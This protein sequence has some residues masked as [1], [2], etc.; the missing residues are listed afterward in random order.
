[1][2]RP[3]VNGTRAAARVLTLAAVLWASGQ[4]PCLA[5]QA[6][7]G[8]KA[9]GMTAAGTGSAGG[10]GGAEAPAPAGEG[11]VRGIVEPRA[12]AQLS[13]EITARIVRMP[14][15]DGEAFSKGDVLAEYDCGRLKAAWRAARAAHRAAAL[16]A[17]SKRRLV[18]FQAAGK[19]EASIA[20]AES[21]RAA[22]EAEA[23]ALEVRKCRVLAPFSGRV[24]ERH[25]QTHE[26]PGAGRPL[27]TIVDTGRLEVEMIAPSRWLAWVR[28]G[29]GF[30]FRLDETGNVL[31]GRL[32][33]I[34]A[35]VDAVSQTVRLRGV[36]EDPEGRALPGMSGMAEFDM[37][38]GGS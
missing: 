12:R 4:A 16:K 23:A 32:L 8:T 1:M 25:A 17:R 24:V 3:Y 10:S 15:K 26:T 6:A 28:P 7:A 37:P 31:K 5:V 29:Q 27:M 20:E 33:R 36:L 13:A 34:G 9:A 30:R 18:K 14:F 22:A 11:M 35:V 21:A 2:F 38:E 19:L